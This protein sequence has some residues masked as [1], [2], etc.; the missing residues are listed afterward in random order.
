[1][2]IDDIIATS[3]PLVAVG[4]LLAAVGQGIAFAIGDSDNPAAVL[5]HRTRALHPIGA[6]LALGLTSLPVPEAMG[7]GLTGRLVWY[8]L[9]GAFAVPLYEVARKAIERRAQ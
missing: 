3:V 2:S 9:A 1:M 7:D 6:G 5:W 4:A 8:G